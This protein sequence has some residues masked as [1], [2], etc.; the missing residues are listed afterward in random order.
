MEIANVEMAAAWDGSE[1]DHFSEHAPRY[2]H[3]T[4]RHAER[5]LTAAGLESGMDVLD[6]GCGTGATTIAAAAAVDP[7]AVLGVD[8]S[9]RM[10]AVARADATNTVN[11][12][13][14]QCDAQDC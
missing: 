3:A 9:S 12:R 14:E 10:L 7:G 2:D 13:F 6:I 11:V 1:G 8:L 4:R 5:L